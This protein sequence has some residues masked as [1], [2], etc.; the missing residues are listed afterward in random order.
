MTTSAAPTPDLV[1]ATFFA[2][3]RTA[4]LKAAVDLAIFT[5]ID[6]GASSVAEIADRCR[7][8]ER[9]TRILCDYLTI[10]GL[11]TKADD[12]YALTR[13]SSMFLSKKSPAYLGT[14]GEFLV[15]PRIMHNFLDL[16]ATVRRGTVAP[17]ANSVAGHEQEHWVT[18]ARAM[19]PMMMPAALA[20]ADILKIAAAGPTKIL[21]IAAGHGV[22]GIVLA[23][24]N[25]RAEV[26]A[27]DWP[28]VL[29]VASENAA[30]MGVQ[31]RHRT[32]P[33][34]AFAVDY[35]GDFDVAL[36]TNF[37]HHFDAPTCT[38][39]LRKVAAALKR[40]GRAVILEFVPNDDRVTPPMAAGF[41]LNM[42]AGTPAGDAYTLAELR[43][44]TAAAGFTG[45][46]S[47]HSLP[48]PETVVVATK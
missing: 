4:A 42:L 33:G 2:Y 8:S 6:E 17:E 9:G 37:L 30:K 21:D 18:F 38:T 41:S 10:S 24:R 15:A 46:V 29:D 14:I 48:T 34:D 16:A 35:G 12:H 39:L 47:A 23:Q 20:I 11:L 31:A 22:F 27:V 26:V 44:M 45:G 32:V 1:F 3:Q 19:T 7:A 36:L 13:E 43:Q 5:A 28:G 25:P 40:G